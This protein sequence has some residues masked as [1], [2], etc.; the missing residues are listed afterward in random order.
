NPR[1]AE[2]WWPQPYCPD[3]YAVLTGSLIG[4]L[5][6]PIQFVGQFGGLWKSPDGG[7]HRGDRIRCA[8]WW[9]HINTPSPAHR[10]RQNHRLLHRSHP[11]TQPQLIWPDAVSLWHTRPPCRPLKTLRFLTIEA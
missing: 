8:R 7:T 5:A 2:S 11:A 1:P 6:G 10:Q 4:R 9:R 3:A